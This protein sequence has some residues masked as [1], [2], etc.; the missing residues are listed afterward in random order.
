MISGE[1]QLMLSLSQNAVVS[2][3][4]IGISATRA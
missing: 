2:K 3:T 1:P 4:A